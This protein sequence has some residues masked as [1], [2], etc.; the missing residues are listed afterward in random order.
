MDLKLAGVLD[1][2][3]ARAVPAW[4]VQNVGGWVARYS[5]GLAAKRV[6]SVW[7]R[8]D[9][10]SSTIEAKLAAVERFY[11][12]RDLPARFQLSPAAH[13]RGLDRALE[14]RGY[15]RSAP[16]SVERCR[17]AELSG[18][19]PGP[20]ID[21]VID[22]APT[23]RWSTT[24]QAALGLTD[25]RLAATARLLGRVTAPVAFA[26]V[27]VDRSPAGV[28]M[29]VL[30]GRWLGIFNMATIPELQRRGVGR[31]ALGALAQWGQCRGADRAYLQVDRG[32]PAARALYR[33]VGF[34]TAYEYAY[35][36]LPGDGTPPR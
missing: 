10:P 31:L 18:P 19:S 30:D 28:G 35:R 11:A 20:G 1:E 24:W 33:A 15:Q 26:T 13:P 34:E 25:A 27:T 23:P 32:N 5:P 36:T 7:P 21:I 16:T 17:L 4:E 3:A 12:A 22:A 14:R 29:G 9:D 8:E 2:V 6:N